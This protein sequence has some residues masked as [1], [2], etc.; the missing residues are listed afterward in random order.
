MAIRE[1]LRVRK[2]VSMRRTARRA[3]REMDRRGRFAGRVQGIVLLW[4]AIPSLVRA[5]IMPIVILAVVVAMLYL[6]CP[7][8]LRALSDAK[9]AT[10]FLAVAWPVTAGSL[11]FSVVVL[12]FAYQTIAAV[13]QS[14]GI[15]DL[16]VGTPLLV[17]VYLGI[18][19]VLA[20]GLVLLGVGYQAPAG[21]AASWATIV[22][23]SAIASL[24]LLI[25]ASLRA[26]DPQMQQSRR[27]RMLRRRIIAAI[28]A[29]AIKRL[30]LTRLISDGEQFGYT[31]SPLESAGPTRRLMESVNSPASGAVFDI[32]L[33]RLRRIAR[34]CGSAG[35]PPLVVTTFI[36]RDIGV[37]TRLAV[38]PKALEGA[39]RRCLAAAFKTT[40]RSQSGPLSLLV[41]AV[42]DLHQ[43]AMQIID[44]G[45]GM[46][47][48]AACEAQQEALLAFPAA[49][50]NLGQAF[51]GDLASGIMPLQAGP[52]ND[53][54][55][56]CPIKR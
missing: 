53:S 49:W 46:A 28:R 8:H 34:S 16:A 56:I 43:E 20:D 14:V 33:D 3:Y 31:V 4:E 52:L 23:G 27:V 41:A 54:A 38:F 18:A 30:A 32:R 6:P 25:A 9:T 39:S 29:E 47:F 50:A 5:L 7:E 2:P 44:A 37:G 15:R 13:R 12:V 40:R 24:A 10:V 35:L 51:T 17:V 36:M 21:W 45:R 19:A 26:V 1:W 48:E 11:A 22:S 55:S 42:D